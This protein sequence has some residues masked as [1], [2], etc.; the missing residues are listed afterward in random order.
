ME[1][2]RITVGGLSGTLKWGYHEAA[3]LGK[4]SITADRSGQRLT[5]DIVSHD[6]F[7]VS[8]RPLTLVVDRPKGQQWCWRIDTLQVTGTTLAATLVPE[9]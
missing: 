9:E 2:N 5:A 6:A 7:K 8:Q 4:W 3:S 1:S